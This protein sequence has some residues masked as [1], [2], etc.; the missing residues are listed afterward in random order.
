MVKIEGLKKEVKSLPAEE[1]RRF[2]RWFLEKDWSDW[3]KQLKNNVAEGRLDF[4][5]DEALK[6]KR[7]VNLAIHQNISKEKI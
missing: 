3:D 7:A 2:R 5:H 4:L 1:Y 6:G